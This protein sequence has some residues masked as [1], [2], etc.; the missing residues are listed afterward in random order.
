MSARRRLLVIALAL[1]ALAT[2]TVLHNQ[3]AVGVPRDEVVYM[4]AGSRYAAWWSGLFSGK[5]QLS[6][7][8][9]TAH[10]GGAS[11]TDNNREHPPLLKTL[12]GMSERVLHDQ[13][14]WTDELTAYRLPAAL[15]HGA[16]IALIALFAGGIWGTAAG[17]ISALLMLL[18]PRPL[19]HAGLACFDGPIAALW[20]A[21]LVAYH[22]ALVTGRR[23]WLAGVC[24]G[25]ALATKH[26]A[27]LLPFAVT[28]HYALTAWLRR[29]AATS[30]STSTEPRS[31]TRR[32]AEA[33]RAL[34][35]LRPG[36]LIAMALVGPLVLFLVWPWLWA[37]P[38]AP[39]RAVDRLPHPPR[40]LQLRI[41]RPQLER[42]AVP[43]ARP[44]RHHLAHRPGDHPGRL[45]RRRAGDGEP[46]ARIRF[47][48]RQA[49]PRW[50]R[51][52][53]RLPPR[54]LAPALAR[55]LGRPVLPAHDADLRAPRST[56][57]RRSRP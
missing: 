48:R 11:A 3:R 29:G 26:N 50:R 32:L 30:T 53:A 20:F 9:I 55:R 2:A 46:R 17:V 38:G 6:R 52:R 39:R 5:T 42:P 1:G 28:A 19:F 18:M 22:R 7:Q 56:G 23:A 47:G 16:L 21:T 44:A 27:L 8:S 13:L 51:G 54:P 14:R 49:R 12:S 43:L 31:V 40:A 15:L 25:L 4:H 34:W 45:A 33:A 57:S 36:V 24:F 37:L 41:P 10:F 35:Q